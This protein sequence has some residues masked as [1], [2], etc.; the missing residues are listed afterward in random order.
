MAETAL[1][2]LELEVEVAEGHRVLAEVAGPEDGQLLIFH[3]GTPG[4]RHVYEDHLRV[5][6]D[7]GLRHACYSRPGYE[8][9]P[10]RPGRAFAECAA[11]SA[12]LADALGAERFHIV[13]L[14]GGGPPALACAALLPE[15]VLS[16][17]TF[18]CHAPHDAEA[19]VWTEGMTAVNVAEYVALEV[20]DEALLASIEA[21]A[22]AMVDDSVES[23][24]YGHE[25]AFCEADRAVLTG[26]YLEFHRAAVRRI[27][28]GGV[29]GWFDDDKAAFG[30]WGF[31][32]TGIEAPV[33]LWHGNE[34]RFVPASH[35]EWLARRIPG[36]EL[37]ILPGHG[38]ISLF[39]EFYP[40]VLDEIKA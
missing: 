12:A 6:A 35:G 37:R 30:A 27:L 8:G 4:S 11:E 33:T 16:A 1:P 40:A 34:D 22:A 21:L 38:H 18:S 20:G 39:A 3:N 19:L 29:W 36:A 28:A 32:P 24:G 14:S 17:T 26:P 5:A 31:E 13:G 15:R 7:L 9:S 23:F 2:R 10:R 25:S